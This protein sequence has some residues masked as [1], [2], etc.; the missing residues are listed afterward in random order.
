MDFKHK[1]KIVDTMR[2]FKTKQQQQKKGQEYCIT[3]FINKTDI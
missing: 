3:K 2:K 1:K